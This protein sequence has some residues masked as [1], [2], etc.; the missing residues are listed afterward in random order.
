MAGEVKGKIYE[1]ITAVAL[2]LALQKLGKRS[3][4]LWHEQ[5]AWISIEPDLAIGRSK[6]S[7]DALFMVT[8]SGSEGYSQKKFWRNAGELFQWKVHGPKPVRCYSILF[9]SSVKRG[10]RVAESAVLDG[11]LDVSKTKWGK[12]LLKHVNE[13]KD[14]YG[15]SDE[16]RKSHVEELCDST[17]PEHDPAFAKAVSAF[18]ADLANLLG[19]ENSSTKPLW[20]L[21]RTVDAGAGSGGSA[22]LTYVRNGLAKLMIFDSVTREKVYVAVAEKQELADD[23]VPSYAAE[24]GLVTEDIA[25]YRIEDAEVI[26]AIAL[27]GKDTCDAVIGAAPSRM[28]DFIDPLRSVGNLDV[29]AEFVA[30]NFKDLTTGRGMKKWLK[31]CYEDPVGILPTGAAIDIPPRDTWLFPFCMTLEKARQGKIVAYGLSNLARDTGFP[32]IGAGGFVVPPFVHREKPLPPEM[33]SSIANVFADKLREIGAETIASAEFIAKMKAMLIQRQ[34]Y[35]LRTYRNFDPLRQ[36]V[37]LRFRE[38][39]IETN[40]TTVCSCQAEFA[41]TSAASSKYLRVAPDTLV[42]WQSVTEAGRIH[43]T[44]ELSARFRAT[45]VQWNGTR[46]VPRPSAKRLFLV[47]DGEWRDEDLQM[48]MRSGVD[49]YFYP[50]QIDKL[51]TRVAA[52]VPPTAPKEIPI[53][54]EPDLAVAAEPTKKPRRGLKRRKGK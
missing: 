44:K 39:G 51:V 25:G 15:A 33:L 53:P 13:N 10:I 20:R 4:V 11:D 41:G 52:V 34:M 16:R 3:K 47:V 46:F 37:R 42:Y 2:T 54:A 50:D 45:K 6:D 31:R 17:S 30:T 8:H 12:A 29:F 48:L 21:L 26:S 1:A 40:D 32:E 49:E 9:D 27:L 5:P 14:S 7:I 36:L 22:R 38:A 23:T 18:A 24:L 19:L 28:N 35:V 43:K